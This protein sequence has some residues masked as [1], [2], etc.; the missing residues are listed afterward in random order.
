MSE[1]Q[2]DTPE[3]VAIEK[4]GQLTDHTVMTV[5]IQDIDRE[6]VVKM[7]TPDAMD[8]LQIEVDEPLPDPPLKVDRRGLPVAM[9]DDPA[10]KRQEAAVAIRRD[11]RR[12]LL[13]LVEPKVPGDTLD[14]RIEN[15]QKLPAHIYHALRDMATQ[16]C[17][18]RSARVDKRGEKFQPEQ[19][20]GNGHSGAVQTNA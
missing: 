14:E 1:Q 17:Y 5:P 20:A 6:I 19:Q 2:Q 10:Y 12:V 4:W 8:V 3:I 16:I 15:L 18:S 9:R 11:E 13:T 7:R